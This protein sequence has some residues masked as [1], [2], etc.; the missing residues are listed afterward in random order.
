MAC[1]SFSA[2]KMALQGSLRPQHLSRG[3]I[4]PF[5]CNSAL[6][7]AQIELQQLVSCKYWHSPGFTGPCSAGSALIAGPLL[8]ALSSIRRRSL[9][10]SS[11]QLGKLHIL[12]LKCP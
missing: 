12:G 10:P 9:P 8:C 11:S 4:T 7:I 3:G 5:G 1:S 6:I 2:V